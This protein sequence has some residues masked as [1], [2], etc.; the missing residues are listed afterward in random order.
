MP[1]SQKQID[2]L[3]AQHGDTL[4]GVVVGIDDTFIFKR[5][6]RAD[7]DRWYDSDRKVAAARELTQAC[8]VYPDRDSYIATLDKMPGVLMCNS[9][10]LDAVVNS[11]GF[12]QGS[13][14]LKKL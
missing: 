12:Q 13:V 9:G 14:T 8:L 1:I 5:P 4:I 6:S 10:F 11:A 2:E 3:K 7:F